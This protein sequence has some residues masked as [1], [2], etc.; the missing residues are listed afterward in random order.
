MDQSWY[1]VAVQPR[2]E[3]AVSNR[4]GVLAID[5]YY[6][7]G[8]ALGR[9]SRRKVIEFGAKRPAMPGYVFV[10]GASHFA[11]FRRDLDAPEAVPHCLGW[12]SGP[13]G[14]EPVAA[15]VI[16]DIRQREQDG[17]FDQAEREGRYWAPRWL[18]GGVKV[19]ITAGAFIGRSGEVWRLTAKRRVAIWLQMLGAPTMTEC[20][21]DWVARCR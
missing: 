21:L 9:K 8:K 2:A 10:N 20:P 15:A 7:I 16:E 6:P 13:E 19:R 14:P 3:E 5:T 18:R 17:E 12:L 11:N 4:A 1:V